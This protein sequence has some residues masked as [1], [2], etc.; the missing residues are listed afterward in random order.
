FTV[1]VSIVPSTNGVD[2][3]IGLSALPAITAGDFAVAMRFNTDGS[4]DASN[5]AAYA[6]VNPLHYAAGSAYRVL[7]VVDAGGRSYS[8]WVN[9]R[10]LAKNYAFRGDPGVPL[11]RFATAV[12]SG[13]GALRACDFADSS[14]DRLTWLHHSELYAEAGGEHALAGRADGALLITGETGTELVDANG[15]VVTTFMHGGRGVAL[16]AASDLYL[17]GEFTGSYDGG[18]GAYASAGG[19]DVFVSK[20]DAQFKHLYTRTLGGAGDDALGA[21]DVNDAG[22]VAVVVGSTL[23]RFD[24]QGA[25]LWTRRVSDER[26]VVAVDA[27]GTVYLAENASG[28]PAFTLTTL[29]AQGAPL[30]TRSATAGNKGAGSVL[31]LRATPGGGVAVSGSISGTLE[32]GGA[33]LRATRTDRAETFVAWLDPAGAYLDG[34][35]L[36]VTP[37]SGLGLDDTG[38]ATIGGYRPNP[39]TYVLERIEF[40][41]S[42]VTGVTEL[43]G[44]ELTRGLF[45]GTA[46][47]PTVDRAGNT[48]WSVTARMLPEQSASFLMKVSR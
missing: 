14:D 35:V 25:L 3:I 41:G 34:S 46:S 42:S 10:L 36:D 40:D 13:A 22:D 21:F 16:D 23:M 1:S 19:T 44:H 8:A 32:L 39:N 48:Y 2:G 7:F 45:L 47:A 4:V 20:Y 28:G 29:T 6:S 26:A 33:P 9:G 38:T 37:N 18:G 17:F 5:G 12:N 27:A 11:A 15:A 24:A 31:A 30:W 43:G